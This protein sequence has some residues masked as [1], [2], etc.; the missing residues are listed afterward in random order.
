MNR[1]WPYGI[2]N[3]ELIDG[4]YQVVEKK[5]QIGFKIEFN[6]FLD[7]DQAK[8]DHIFDILRSGLFVTEAEIHDAL[9]KMINPST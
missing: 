3:L 8:R 4:I 9:K 2:D 5:K 6:P 1:E 7:K